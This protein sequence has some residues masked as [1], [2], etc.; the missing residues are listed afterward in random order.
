MTVEIFGITF[1]IFEFIVIPLFI[2]ITP[3]VLHSKF[4]VKS[5]VLI[6][7]YLLIIILFLCSILVSTYNAID[8]WKVAKAFLKWMEIFSLS[9]FVFLYCSSIKRFKQIWWLLILILLSDILITITLLALVDP[10]ISYSIL[11]QLPA[12][13]SLFLL[14]LILPFSIHSRFITIVSVLLGVLILLS[15]T[16]GTWLGLFIIMVYWFWKTQNLLQVLSVTGLTVTV[17]SILLL[18]IPDIKSFFYHK[19]LLAFSLES[20]SNL[21][22]LGMAIAALNFFLQNPLTGIGAEN[23]SK[24]LFKD[25]IPP[26]VTSQNPEMLTPHNYFLQIAA[27][28]GV[29]GLI[30]L[31]ALLFVLYKILFKLASSRAI[32][33]YVNGLQLFFIAMIISLLFGYVAGTSRLVLGL[34]IGLTLALS[35]I[36]VQRGQ[37]QG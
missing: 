10:Q 32:P 14:S 23:F 20:S 4:K 36:S 37:L 7:M 2:L 18:A 1:N 31:S 12:Y 26:F 13:S 21:E 35:R 33:L 6:E 17:L 30:A 24:H 29:I 25:T 27:E 9:I 22:R 19:I 3:A 11:R 8:K 16:R 28:N 34:Y 15:L 5:K